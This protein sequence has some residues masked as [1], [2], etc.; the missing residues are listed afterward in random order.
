MKAKVFCFL[1]DSIT[2][3]IGVKIGERYCD[4]IGSA[5]NVEAVSYGVNGAHTLDL[6][7]QV[8]CMHREQGSAVD[9]IFVLIGTNDFYYNVPI[10]N[11]FEEYIDDFPILYDNKGLVKRTKKRRKRR[12]FYDKKSFCGRLNLLFDRIREYYPITRIV[13]LTPIHRGYAFLGGDNIQPDDLTTNGIDLFFDEYV[14]C[15]RK[16]ADIRSVELIDLYRECGLYPLNDNNARAF[17]CNTKTDRLHPNANGHE[18]M[19]E[20]IL[21]HLNR[22]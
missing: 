1:G 6:L 4:I 9:T 20:V 16:C 21:S 15:V 12:F 17:Y 22:Y 7:E 5:L 2:E 14:E 10:G 18:R 19:A 13:L 11:F 8:E 3:G